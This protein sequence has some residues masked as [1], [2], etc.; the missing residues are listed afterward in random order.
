MQ[1]WTHS[2]IDRKFSGGLLVVSFDTPGRS[3]EGENTLRWSLTAALT[4]SMSLAFKDPL[5]VKN[6]SVVLSFSNFLSCC[7]CC[8]KHL[9]AKV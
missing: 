8:C 5:A 4:G 7:C 3:V 9:S 1:Q 2:L 6:V